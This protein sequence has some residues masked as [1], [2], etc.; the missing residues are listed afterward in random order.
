MDLNTL[1]SAVT[2]VSLLLFL[3]LVVSVCLPRR[4]EEFR[5]AAE[6]PF[7]DEEAQP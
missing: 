6:L 3:L 5:K 4:R 7:V 1:R 2:L